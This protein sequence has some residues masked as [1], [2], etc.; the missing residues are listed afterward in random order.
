VA[1]DEKYFYVID[2]ARIARHD[3]QTGQFLNEWVGQPGGAIRHLNSGIVQ[4][5]LLVCS[6]SNFPE[7]PMNNSLEFFDLVALQP[8]KSIAVTG[9]HGSLVWAERKAGFRWACFANYDG[10]GGVPGRDHRETLFAKF[11]E[12]F[13]LVETWHFPPQVLAAFKPMSSSGGSWGD[14]GLLYVTVHDAKE[15]YVLRLPKSGSTLE[16]ITTID[17]PFEGQAWSWDRSQMRVLYAISRPK[18]EVAIVRVPEI[19]ADLMRH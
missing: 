4:D 6:H 14:D 15:L 8:V 7:L 16:Y 1:V 13:Q 18:G 10:V 19:A 5:G 2:D 3:K 11:D 17:V 12:Q 9:E